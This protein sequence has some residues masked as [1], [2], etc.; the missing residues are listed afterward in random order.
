[1]HPFRGGFGKA[2]AME[3]SN[4]DQVPGTRFQDLMGRRSEVSFIAQTS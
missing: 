3:L 1:M 4:S 2:Y